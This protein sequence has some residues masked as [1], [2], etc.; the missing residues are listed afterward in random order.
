M[1]T[2]ITLLK[3]EYW[4]NRSSFF[5]TPLA[6]AGF[7]LALILVTLFNTEHLFEVHTSGLEKLTIFGISVG[8]LNFLTEIA[9]K[10]FSHLD[11]G[12]RTEIWEKGF[13]GYSTS[14]T[15]VL[16][17][18]SI[19]YLLGSLYDDR[20][21][22]SILFWKSL[23]VSD[24][25][26]VMSKLATVIFV[27]PAIYVAATTISFMIVM[28]IAS[29]VTLIAGGSVW[30]SIW[31]PA[32]IFSAP[33]QLYATYV[34]QSLWA[35]PFIGWLLLVSSWTKRKPII[36]AF[37]P[38]AVITFMEAYNYRTSVFIDAV[39]QRAVGWVAPIDFET[40]RH[41]GDG[42]LISV[43]E[44]IYGKAHTLISLPAFWSGLAIAGVMVFGAIY[45]RR[46]RDES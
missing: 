41:L 29:V 42:N 13:Y 32:P 23:P 22:K 16:V 8:D 19:V 11:I 35:S 1:N 9:T 44:V 14:F 27:I 18:I 33:L 10:T 2:I 36:V 17:I 26:T 40:G 24:L 39:T 43:Q 21:D 6:I 15:L 28:L 25:T 20:K 7:Y 4:E 30:E 34:I 12:L 31:H 46:Y 38:I 5:I 45:I 3:R 37:I